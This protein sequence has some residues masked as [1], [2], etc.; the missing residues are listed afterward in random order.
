MVHAAT[1]RQAQLNA[2]ATDARRRAAEEATVEA[3]HAI[4]IA[5]TETRCPEEPAAA[6][7]RQAGIDVIAE[8]HR[9]AAAA[10]QFD[11]LAAATCDRHRTR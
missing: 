11:A 3:Y 7:V 5:S 10:A 1:A 8:T 6:E 2:A 4:K 9:V